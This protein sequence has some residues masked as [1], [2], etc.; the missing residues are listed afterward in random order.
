ME[1]NRGSLPAA[2]CPRERAD[3]ERRDEERR[4]KR[5]WEPALAKREAGNF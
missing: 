4:K 3:W 2:K 1:K 5:H